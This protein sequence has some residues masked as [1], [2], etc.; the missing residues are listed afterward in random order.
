MHPKIKIA[1]IVS[2]FPKISETFIVHK[3]LGLL[4]KG[5]DVHVFCSRSEAEN[6]EKF[7]NLKSRFDLRQ[8]VHKGWPLEPR[9][10]L[11]FLFPVLFLKILILS[12]FRVW[13]YFSRG[14]RC[15]GLDIFRRFYLDS[16]LVLLGPN[17][18]HFEFGAL[19]VGRTYLKEL[20]G[21]KLA[22]SF[23]GYDLNFSGLDQPGYYD[24]VWRA[25]DG[26]HCLGN[27]LWQR[28]MKR[29]CP[30]DKFHAFIPPAIDTDFFEPNVPHPSPLPG[31]EGRVRVL[32]VGRL[33]WKKGYEFSLAA[34]R[35]LKDQGFRLDYRIVGDGNYL[36]A[37]A[38]CRHQLGLEDCVHFLGAMAPEQIREEINHADIFLHAAVTEG[39]C[40]AVLEAQAMELPVVCSDAGGLPENVIHGK[41]GFIVPRRDSV[42][43]AE[44]MG[45]LIQ[46]P[47][48]RKRMGE[49][50]RQRVLAHF[51]LSEQIRVFED[52]Y[53]KVLNA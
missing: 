24:E 19:A 14:L 34:V 44:K 51:Q 47:D 22:V 37:I 20:L 35:I 36:E 7:K 25:T 10:I 12:P 23:R 43:L 8:K 30:P 53:T 48:L 32:S 42:A 21:T 50:G 11:I 17:L 2:D 26:I 18:I 46:N 33:E 40:N 4:K 27:D 6:F 9:P 5:W 13:Q 31:G 38:F 52:F 1:L 28:A 29:D 39:F 16:E 15:F 49:A 3:F 41:T 45:E